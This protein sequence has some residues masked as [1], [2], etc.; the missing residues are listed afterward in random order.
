MIGLLHLVQGQNRDRDHLST[1]AVGG[2]LPLTLL[3]LAMQEDV[4]PDPRSG[5]AIIQSMTMAGGHTEIL[6]MAVTEVEGGI[7]MIFSHM[8]QGEGVGVFLL[9]E[10]HIELIRHHPN[11]DENVL[12]VERPVMHLDHQVII[13]GVS[14]LQEA[15]KTNPS[16]ENVLGPILQRI[17]IS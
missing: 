4:D 10:N 3:H 9:E 14:Y 7:Q 8:P 11:I 5:H 12:H 13:R 17:N 16:T 15:M 1:I 6:G 2:S